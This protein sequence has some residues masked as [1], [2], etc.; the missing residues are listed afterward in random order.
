MPMIRYNSEWR[1]SRS[2]FRRSLGTSASVEPYFGIQHEEVKRHLLR[3]LESPTDFCDHGRKCVILA[4]P[5]SPPYFAD[6]P[7]KYT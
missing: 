4:P 2:A 1:K 6:T 3:L 7:P 5:F